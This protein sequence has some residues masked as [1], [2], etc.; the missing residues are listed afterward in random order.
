MIREAKTYLVQCDFC[1]ASIAVQVSCADP[2]PRDA[3]N[4]ARKLK[5]AWKFRENYDYVFD[6]DTYTEN[7]VDYIEVL[8]PREHPEEQYRIGGGWT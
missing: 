4:E 6:P 8:C 2:D 5:L 7:R 1:D 3:A